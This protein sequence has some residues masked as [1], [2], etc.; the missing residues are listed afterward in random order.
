MII[1]SWSIFEGGR[2]AGGPAFPLNPLA[3]LGGPAFP[4]APPLKP[5]QILAR[6]L[7]GGGHPPLKLI[8][9]KIIMAT[10]TLDLA[11]ILAAHPDLAGLSSLSQPLIK[12][13]PPV[14]LPD[15]PTWN[16]RVKR[17]E[18]IA[19]TLNKVVS[20]AQEDLE[21][22]FLDLRDLLIDKIRRQAPPG[23]RVEG[24]K[25]VYPRGKDPFELC[26][27]SHFLATR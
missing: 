17:A 15:G 12:K 14:N 16:D 2:C 18:K 11:P 23:F 21:E 9:N 4:I 8:L 6:G 1:L 24:L 27:N 25:L 22:Q 20:R 10:D 7:R 13:L 5:E 26:L 3:N 19:E